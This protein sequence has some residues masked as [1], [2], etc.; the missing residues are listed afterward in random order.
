MQEEMEKAEFDIAERIYKD[1]GHVGST[2][3]LTLD[4]ALD[5]DIPA[6]TDVIIPSGQN[7]ESGFG[8]LAADAR[9]GDRIILIRYGTTINQTDHVGC[10]VGGLPNPKTNGCKQR[11]RCCF[12]SFFLWFLVVFNFIFVFNCVPH[13]VFYRFRGGGSGF[14]ASGTMNFPDLEK[15]TNIPTKRLTKI[16]TC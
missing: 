13:S 9:Q 15:A 8:S 16:S 11:F 3:V 2:A 14:V 5:Q 12:L 1:G 6:G 10:Q 4:L 7:D